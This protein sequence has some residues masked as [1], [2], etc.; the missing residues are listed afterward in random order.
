MKLNSKNTFVLMFGASEYNDAYL[1]DI[2]NINLNFRELKRTLKRNDILGIPESNFFVAKNNTT[3]YTRKLIN[4]AFNRS[5]H[6]S[7][8]LIIYYSGHGLIDNKNQMEYYLST[9][10]TE[11]D[12]PFPEGI[13]ALE[14]ATFLK[15]CHARRKIVIIDSCYSG[16]M[17]NMMAPVSEIVNQNF[18]AN[19]DIKGT[20][21]L[22]STS[23]N[24]PSHFPKDNPNLPTY[25]TGEIL[26]ILKRGVSGGKELISMEDIYFHTRE[27][28]V[29]KNLPEP[30]KLTRG[31]AEKFSLAFNVQ[32]SDEQK[33]LKQIQERPTVAAIA[34]FIDSTPNPTLK[35]DAELLLE[36]VR[37]KNAWS[38]T[39]KKN[40]E[41]A[42][43][44][45]LRKYK[46]GV[47]AG[48]AKEALS[49]FAD[50]ESWQFT[51]Q[52]HS[53]EAYRRYLKRFPDGIHQNTARKRIEQLK[54]D[55]K[56][57]D[58]LISSKREAYFEYLE[59]F[60]AGQYTKE[61]VKS[62][63]KLRSQS[64]VKKNTYQFRNKT[65][66]EAYS[67]ML[68]AEQLEMK[69]N[70]G[71]ALFFYKEALRLLPANDYLQNKNREMVEVL[72]RQKKLDNKEG[73]L[74]HKA[75]YII[76]IIL[77]F[78]L[79]ITIYYVIKNWGM[80]NMAAYQNNWKQAHVFAKQKNYSEAM[81]LILEMQNSSNNDSLRDFNVVIKDELNQ[82]NENITKDWA[83][84]EQALSKKNLKLAKNILSKFHKEYPFYKNLKKMDKKYREKLIIYIDKQVRIADNLATDEF[85]MPKAKHI[86]QYCHFLEPDNKLINQRIIQINTTINDA[87]NK[88]YRRALLCMESEIGDNDAKIYLKKALKL[89]P[90][91]LDAKATLLKLKHSH[92][93]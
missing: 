58:C 50:K 76:G 15:N 84:F 68:K 35:R 86:Y 28:L 66:K 26:K 12:N 32:L 7:K 82:Q 31:D 77:T 93:N 1:D 25:F 37:E 40:T 67:L 17:L 78:F 89:K 87:F 44:S 49:Q 79:V 43:R 16:K 83:L 65:I 36:Q 27:G 6:L 42:Y 61:A 73:K 8:T 60:P 75:G 91:D 63:E 57:K 21:V 52:K 18:N 4:D 46:K 51:K 54:D 90:N 53:L 92:M 10:Y 55:A 39:Q 74:S 33:V 5:D 9:K 56:W 19:T 3:K 81:A 24:L 41:Q 62:L 14:L 71:D 38:R 48:D 45:F 11:K 47:F 22:T 2:P 88:Y 70:F 85:S 72:Q 64:R 13:K 20:F 23:Q 29:S 69:P 30:E 59:L 34:N 80:Q